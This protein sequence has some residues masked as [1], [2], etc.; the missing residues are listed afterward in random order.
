MIVVRHLAESGKLTEVMYRLAETVP[1]P[2]K[3]SLIGVVQTWGDGRAVALGMQ[4]EKVPI[5]DGKCVLAGLAGIA[6]PRFWTSLRGPTRQDRPDAWIGVPGKGILIIEA[7]LPT[8]TLDMVQLASYARRFLPSASAM[9]LPPLADDGRACGTDTEACRKVLAG[10]VV[11]WTWE[12]FRDALNNTD[13]TGESRECVIG[14]FLRNNLCDLLLDSGAGPY[15]ELAD[16]NKRTDGLFDGVLRRK[17]GLFVG[18]L[19]SEWSAAGWRIKGFAEGLPNPDKY[20]KG[21]VPRKSWWVEIEPEAGTIPKNLFGGT[22][23]LVLWFSKTSDEVGFEWFEVAHGAQLS[24]VLPLA[25]AIRLGREAHRVRRD[26]WERSVGRT[27]EWIEKQDLPIQVE[28]Q[29]RRLKPKMANWFQN[30]LVDED[31][32]EI[33]CNQARKVWRTYQSASAPVEN[34]KMLSEM[35]CDHF[36]HW[37]DDSATSL[38]EAAGQMRKPS[39]AFHF[40]GLP[41]VDR[42]FEDPMAPR[43]IREQAERLLLELRRLPNETGMPEVWPLETQTGPD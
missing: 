37:P 1:S 27:C 19:A 34:G 8:G 29:A 43:L 6:L 14:D 20:L 24:K 12:Q 32:T 30:T 26:A 31:G 10:M 4:D 25:E 7:K 42:L 15:R 11:A 22:G 2:L 18:R 35:W 21:R 3:E 13:L 40:E 36:W 9:R 38:L 28:I 39:I 41:P 5:G 33:P 23:S 17:I 16:R